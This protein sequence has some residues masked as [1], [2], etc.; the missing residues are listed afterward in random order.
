MRINDSRKGISGLFMVAAVSILAVVVGAVS[1]AVPLWRSPGSITNTQTTTDK[2]LGI[3]LALSVTPQ[4]GPSGTTFQINATV[5][6]SLARVN[7]VTGVNDYRGVEGNP[8]CNFAP[9]AFEVLQGSYTASNFASGT[10][11]NIHGVQ[12]YMCLIGASD[13]KSYAFQPNSD[14]F[15]GTADGG[16]PITRAAHASVDVSHQWSKDLTSSGPL[17]P[18]VYTV[19]AADNWGQLAVVHFTVS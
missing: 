18:G 9:V 14:V 8:V 11:V 13:L 5:L 10:A 15:S 2:S 1:V 19:V 16:A 6:N 17:A 3:S 4:S 7:N 12:N